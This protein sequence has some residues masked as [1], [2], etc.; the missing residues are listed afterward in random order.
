MLK[1]LIYT[2]LF[3]LF[4]TSA[5]SQNISVASFKI[6]PNDNSA[7]IGTYKIDHNGD[8]CAIIKIVTTQ[9]GFDW[10]SDAAGIIAVDYK[11]GEYWLYIPYG[12]KRLTIRH[13]LLGVLRDYMYPIPT[14]KATVYEMILT[15]GKVETTIVKESL[16][17]WLVIIPEPADARIFIDNQFVKTGEYSAK[18]KS[19]TYD[20]RVESLLYHPEAGKVEMRNKKVELR[21]NLK[22]AY[23]FLQINTFP[24]VGAEIIITGKSQ[25]LL[26]PHKSDK[27]ASGEYE[28]QVFKEMFKPSL[29]TVTITDNNTT[30]LN[31]TMLPNFAE[32]TINSLP[33]ARIMINDE[34]KG[35]GSW[36]GRL[37]PAFYTFSSSLENHK[38]DITNIEINAGDNKTIELNPIPIY[39]SLDV[40]TTPIG[41]NLSINGQNYTTP[42]T[43]KELLVGS[44][45]VELSKQG[46]QAIKK[47]IQIKEGDENELIELL[48]ALATY[49]TSKDN[50][51]E[52][53]SQGRVTDVDGNVYTTVTIGTQTWMVENLKTT[54]YRNGNSIGTTTPASLKTSAK[55]VP[56]YQWAYNNSESYVAT[57][58]RLYTWYAATDSRGIC[59]TGWH[60][61]SDAE[62]E[63]LTT[64]LGGTGIAGGKLKEMGTSHWKSP[65]KGATNS[66]GFRAL[67][68]GYCFSGRFRYIGYYGYWWSSTESNTFSAWDRS[69]DYDGSL[70]YRNYNYETSGL[71]V[72]CVRD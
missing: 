19:G 34:F 30:T 38:N 48:I 53:K 20:Y 54:K 64:F 17:E 66:S 39:G 28:V 10:D 31:V 29:H 46:Y 61:P 32:V 18:F 21:V 8:K 5:N 67:P 68:G 36:S 45:N 16:G 4:C 49:T 71:S 6:L 22:P 23:G 51:I 41:A 11:P 60:L 42:Y 65:N 70:V 26:S 43:I 50:K 56:K 24:E 3:V 15:T 59:P 33:G 14:E 27:M 69:M 13:N 35:I 55:A 12:A 72:R 7:R 40:I 37:N 52:P 57:Y 9:T 63:M 2:L 44:Y 1:K 25:A 47:T 58:G 62:W